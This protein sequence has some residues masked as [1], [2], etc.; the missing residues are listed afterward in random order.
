[1]LIVPCILPRVAS[2]IAMINFH[3]GVCR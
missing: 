3:L 1:V 2:V